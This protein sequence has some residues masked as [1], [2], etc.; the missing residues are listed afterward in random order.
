MTRGAPTHAAS[1]ETESASRAHHD[2]GSARLIGTRAPRSRALPPK[3]VNPATHASATSSAL[4]ARSP[5]APLAPILCSQAVSTKVTSPSP[6]PQVA[7]S[8]VV[9][10]EVRGRLGGRLAFE[11]SVALERHRHQFTRVGL[12]CDKA[13]TATGQA[14]T[15]AIVAA[16]AATVASGRPAPL[17]SQR[18]TTRGTRCRP[19]PVLPPRRSAPRPS[20]PF[21]PRS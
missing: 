3:R 10:H 1:S 16:Y 14:L 15:A 9:G 2:G 4:S 21:P 12:R 18:L 11:G 20:R 17:P 13:V 5:A 19:S 8:S 6:T 7:A